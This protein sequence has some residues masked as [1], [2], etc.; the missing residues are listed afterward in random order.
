MAKISM[1][2]QGAERVQFGGLRTLSLL[3][4]GDVVLLALI[5]CNLQH[6]LGGLQQS[7]K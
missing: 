4:A 3:F 2:S 6:A 1:G 5:G 7:V